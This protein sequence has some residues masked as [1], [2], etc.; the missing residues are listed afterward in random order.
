MNSALEVDLYGNLNSTHLNGTQIVNGI[1]GSGDFNRNAMI[2]VAAL[3]SATRDG[4][5]S[6]V[7]PM[8]PHVDHTEHDVDIVVTDQG[9]ADLRG[10]SP[11]ERATEIISVAS[12]QFKEELQ[13]YFNR[14]KS[15][16]GHISH[17]IET[18]LYWPQQRQQ[19]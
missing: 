14:G 6:R 1:G 8:V 18:A 7:V 15:Y 12:P 13:E 10:K 4:N 19:E 11:R 16:G 5:I 9:I 17:D 2:T 3:P